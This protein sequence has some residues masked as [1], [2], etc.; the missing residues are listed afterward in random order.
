M[1][2]RAVRTRGS[3]D[4]TISNFIGGMILA[5]GVGVSIKHWALAR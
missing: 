3:C 5:D 2:L 4:E 1:H